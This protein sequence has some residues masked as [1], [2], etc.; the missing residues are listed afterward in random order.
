MPIIEWGQNWAFMA[1]QKVLSWTEKELCAIAMSGQSTGR[2]WKDKSCL[3]FKPPKERA[4]KERAIDDFFLA[5]GFCFF[6]SFLLLIA[7]APG[8][9]ITSPEERLTD[10]KQE[11]RARDLSRR[12]RCPVCQSQSIDGSEAPLAKDLR[13]LLRE[14]IKA[15]DSDAEIEDYLVQRYGEF[16]R[17]SPPLRA[18]TLVLWLGP[19]LVTLGLFGALWAR[20][21]RASRTEGE[22][23]E[24]H[25]SRHASQRGNRKQGQ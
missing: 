19:F 3:P 13:L 11:E 6:L 15:G 1:F 20:Q 7:A 22:Q 2:V 5:L 23:Q 12:L 18:A 4:P 16:I 21:R 25:S 8:F 17:F 10:P 9:A 14:R 24:R